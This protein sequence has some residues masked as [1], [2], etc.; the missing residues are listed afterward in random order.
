[1]RL[2]LHCLSDSMSTTGYALNGRCSL[3]SSHSGTRIPSHGV[4]VLQDCSGVQ[5]K[6]ER[7]SPP[8][9]TCYSSGYSRSAL[10]PAHNHTAASRLRL[11]YPDFMLPRSHYKCNKAHKRSTCPQNGDHFEHDILSLTS[12]AGVK[13]KSLIC[14]DQCQN[15]G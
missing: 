13:S 14:Q 11:H 10:L 5:L 12:T 7:R 15:P 8:G 1:M 3:A 9:K 6:P 4:F 2:P